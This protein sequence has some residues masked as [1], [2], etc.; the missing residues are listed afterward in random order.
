ML[1]D[2]PDAKA[3]R[4]FGVGAIGAA[5]AVADTEEA[6]PLLRAVHDATVEH[7][8]RHGVTRAQQVAFLALAGLVVDLGEGEAVTEV[9]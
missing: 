6:E 5:L 7:I 3:L 4:Q 8:H 1:G 9:A 2:A